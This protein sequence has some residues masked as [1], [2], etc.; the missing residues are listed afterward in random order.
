M[1]EHLRPTGE[2]DRRWAAVEGRDAAVDGSFVYGVLT[3]GVF[4]R[5][6]CPSRRPRRE[7]VRFFE[8]AAQAE[9]S[10]LRPC[11]RCRPTGQ[12]IQA[13]R[14]ELVAAACRI[15][16]GAEE[17]PAL[18]ALAAEVGV[19]RFHLHRVFKEETGITPKAYADAARAARVRRRLRDGGPVT[20]AIYGAG[21]ASNGPF[22]ASSNE[23]LGMTPSQFRDGA[24][25]VEV[26]FAVGQ[27]SLGA[28]LVAVSPR[29]VCA[30]EFGDDADLLVRQLQDRFHA[31]HL[32]GDDDEFAAVMARAV[33]LVEDPGGDREAL[34]LDVR[35]TAF[36]E[37]VWQALRRVPPG[38]TVSY[39]QVAAM[40]GAP[41]SV[42]AV[43]GA[44][45]ANHLAVA[46]PCHR[47]V[48]TDGDLSGYRWG[49]E[50]KATLL[51][52]EGG[53]KAGSAP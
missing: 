3:T 52:R 26:R 38:S 23:R 33:A 47:V 35:G 7:N 28:I 21:F 16:D 24:A 48:R 40:I 36:Q 2:N 17:A 8:T 53:A 43:A 31:A 37:R 5:P 34:P 46:I 44:C 22:Y 12:G 30:I 51:E 41:R 15:I 27:C 6:S 25:E 49:V 42:R 10:G 20:G 9:A 39:A 13:R 45:A 11:K 1:S 29:G 32:V 18:A 14:A 50:R 4:C 19:G